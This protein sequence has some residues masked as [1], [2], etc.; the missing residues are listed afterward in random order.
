M[1][2]LL[3]A[4]ILRA[5]G[6]PVTRWF[7]WLT[8]ML[9][10]YTIT[11]GAA[12]S[13]IRAC[14]M[15]A[16]MLA[17]PFL[18]RKPDSLSALAV[19]AIVILVASPAQLGDLGF[20][21]SFTA[22]AGLLA[23]QPV[24]ESGLRRMSRGDAWQLPG[25][26]V[27]GMARGRAL[28]LSAVRYGSVSLS[29]WIGTSPLTAYFFNLFSPVALAMNLIVIPSAF[30]ILLAGVMSLLSALFSDA[31]SE[32]FN[33]AARVVASFLT[34]CIQWAAAVPGGH[35]FIRTPPATGVLAWYGVLGAATIMARRVRGAFAA[36][37]AVLAVLALGWGAWDAH[38]CRV[39]VLDVGEGNAVLV[40]AELGRVLVDAGPG[41]RWDDT[42]RALRRE[43]VNQLDALVLTHP[44][45][46]HMGAA[47]P[48]MEEV[49]VREVWVPA[50]LWNSPILKEILRQAE[51][52]GIP[53]RRL[54]AGDSGS[55]PGDLFWEVLWPPVPAEMARADDASL[56]LRVAR[57]GVSMLLAGDAGE[58]QESA[59]RKAGNSLAASILL[60]GQH[61]DAGATSDGWLDA[62]RPRDAIISAGPHA[63]GRHP[64]EE[65]LERLATRGIR[66][67]R[68]DQQGT[69]DVE[70]DGELARWP[71]PGYRMGTH[72]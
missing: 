25:E 44:D 67:W 61:G 46:Q 39:S 58:A 11:T 20:L 29:A 13:A 2:T 27:T 62:V 48:V 63:D 60:A 72:P 34:M 32:V 7:L 3:L 57:H 51:A 68:T 64:D 14:T 4:G 23:I 47:L 65:T 1:V 37:L 45:A 59:M 66:I 24:M 41:F 6:V 40:Q 12:T 31:C 18:K 30:V 71:D 56:V 69:I 36:G 10:V 22:V 19:A 26:E 16:L 28:A 50:V 70:L 53:I 33:H 42:V 8:P 43:G 35:W 49:P 38:R 17:A 9:A 54:Q 15:A 55:W 5:L 52:G 21:L